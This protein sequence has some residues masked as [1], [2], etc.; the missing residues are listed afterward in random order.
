MPN[1]ISK[2]KTPT[3]DLTATAVESQALSTNKNLGFFSGLTVARKEDK[4]RRE[5]A[6]K[7]IEAQQREAEATALL[8][9]QGRG[10]LVRSEI[11]RQIAEELAAVGGA[12]FEMHKSIVSIQAESRMAAT[13]HNIDAYNENLGEIKGRI[14]QGKFTQQQAEI[15]AHTATDLMSEVESRSDR[16]YQL[17]KDATDRNLEAA[18]KPISTNR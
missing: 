18:L 2:S 5:I 4:A 1:Y 9:I 3:I 11:G 17:L 15:A 10:Q 8:A 14:A 16:A 6:E 7:A 12:V 13:F